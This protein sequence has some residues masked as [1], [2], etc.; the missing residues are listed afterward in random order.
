MRGR[1]P[2]FIR[3]ESDGERG[4]STPR[5]A[6]AQDTYSVANNGRPMGL[7][8]TRSRALSA[9]RS[10]LIREHELRRVQQRPHNI[11]DSLPS[12][13]LGVGEQLQACLTLFLGRPTRVY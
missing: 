3:A 9:L 12:R 7:R 2:I 5:F 6:V 11:F 13:C 4:E 8:G 1:G 10:A